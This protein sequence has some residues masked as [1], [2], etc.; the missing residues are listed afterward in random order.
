MKIYA[1][2]EETEYGDYKTADGKKVSLSWGHNIQAPDGKK[3]EELGYMPFDSVEA[4][5]AAFGLMKLTQEELMAAHS[6][7][8]PQV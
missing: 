8:M 2:V 5:E 7:A 3:N 6:A 1:K 4:A